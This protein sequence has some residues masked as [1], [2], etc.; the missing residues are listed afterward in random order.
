MRTARRGIA[1]GKQRLPGRDRCQSSD[2]S[3]TSLAAVHEAVDAP[4]PTDA[5]DALVDGLVEVDDQ[6]S[7]AIEELGHRGTVAAA[8]VR[9]A[10][11]DRGLVRR[12]AGQLPVDAVGVG[13]RDLATE[14]G[15]VGLEAAPVAEAARVGTEVLALAGALDR[16]PDGGELALHPAVD[17]SVGTEMMATGS[18]R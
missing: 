9:N 13:P 14:G 12:G 8:W 1:A 7:G 6:L 3:P 2:Q 5:V 15:A 10:C 11:R 4:V 17:R 16:H 18:A